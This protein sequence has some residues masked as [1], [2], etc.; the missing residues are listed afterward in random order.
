MA[1]AVSSRPLT[2]GDA[3]TLALASLGGALEFYDFIIYVF[4]AV[5]IGRLFFPPDMPEWLEQLQTFG[6]FAAGY[7]ARPLGGVILAHFGDKTGRKRMFTLSIFMMALPTLIIGILPTYESIGYLAPLLLLVMRVFQ[8]A[9]I[10]GEAPGAWVFVSEHV[11]QNRIGLACGLLTGGLTGGILLGSLMA[12]LIN[13]VYTPTEIHDFA[14]RI[15]F[16]VGGVFGL[17]AMYLRRWLHET[18]VFEAMR[19][20]KTLV[21]DMPLKQV[22][23]GYRPAVVVSMLVTWMLTAIVVVIILMTPTLM[24]RLHGLAPLVTLYASIAATLGITLSAFTIGAL[25][26]RFGLLRVTLAGGPFFVV[27]AYA[28]FIGTAA[29]TAYLI[30]LSALA[31]IGAGLINVVPYTMVKAFP[32]YVRF[33]GVSF[34]YNVAYAIFGGL[35]PIA[36]Q[37]LLVA[38]GLGPVHYVAGA[39]VIGIGAIVVYS[40]RPSLGLAGKVAQSPVR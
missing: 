16:I 24:Q 3:K 6:I 29:D 9:A 25:I 26:D 34:S 22:L 17:V 36:V 21:A 4:F 19:A 31:G 1:D 38:D 32:D 33:T 30:P 8:G 11:P 7:L 23:S 37:L 12:T 14:W 13:Y 35:T 28:L 40:L 5:V 27:T 20:R 18:P 15:P 10:G 2:R 39:T